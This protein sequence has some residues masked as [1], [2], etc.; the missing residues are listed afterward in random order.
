[1][2]N[3][4]SNLD[5]VIYLSETGFNEGRKFCYSNDSS[6]SLHAVHALLVNP[7]FRAKI[8]KQYLVA[9]AEAYDEGD[10]MPD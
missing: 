8:F 6:R 3:A 1:M 7:V 2:M 9:W 5:D 10:V 4:D